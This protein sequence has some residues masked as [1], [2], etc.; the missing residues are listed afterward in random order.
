VSRGCRTFR[1]ARVPGPY[2]D[3]PLD[4][5]AQRVGAASVEHMCKTMVMENTRAPKDVVDCS[6][7]NLSK[8]Y[9]VLV[10]YCAN[11]DAEKLKGFI[12]QVRM[13]TVVRTNGWLCLRAIPSLVPIVMSSQHPNFI[14]STP[15]WMYAST[16]SGSSAMLELLQIVPINGIAA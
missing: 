11:I 7:P 3:K 16:G 14:R 4:F 6:E 2:Y 10:Q 5:R 13:L 15:A 8:Y 12:L 9:M 1:F